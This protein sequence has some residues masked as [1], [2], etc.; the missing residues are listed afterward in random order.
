MDHHTYTLL[1][2]VNGFRP[3]KSNSAAN[4]FPE[5]IEEGSVGVAPPSTEISTTMATS[6]AATSGAIS[7][8]SSKGKPNR[9]KRRRRDFVGGKPSANV[10]GSANVFGSGNNSKS[11]LKELG[12]GE[13][14][15]DELS[16]CP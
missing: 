16:G 6:T 12:H 8:S 5:R 15:E 7:T 9:R 4:F 3:S 10:S 14:V 11:S 2:A 1:L 13:N